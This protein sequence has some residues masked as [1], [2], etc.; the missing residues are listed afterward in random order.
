[1]NKE[2]ADAVEFCENVIREDIRFNEEQNILAGANRVGKRLLERRNEL[3]KAYE[4]I[5][6]KLHDHPYAIKYFFQHITTCPVIWN[7]ESI[8]QERTSKARLEEINIEISKLSFDLAE[9]LKERSVL[10]NDSSYRDGT[11]YHVC[12][13]IEKSANSLFNLY[14][15]EDLFNLTCQF[16]L[17]YWPSLEDFVRE[18]GEDASRAEIHTDDSVAIE[19]TKSQRPSKADVIRAFIT[20]LD[21]Y[22][23][24]NR[25]RIPD[26]FSLSDETWASLINCVS[27]FDCNNLIDG[28][29]IKNVRN[30]KLT[31]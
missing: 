11:H 14:V 9:L 6:K 10:N 7:E 28:T 31:Q 30:R 4:E 29:Y 19:A 15:K 27:N 23:K 12:D 5:Y 17:K 24:G 1:M 21:D 8:A 20:D 3:E 26:D 2:N 22:K 16:S 18:I 13:I 25:R